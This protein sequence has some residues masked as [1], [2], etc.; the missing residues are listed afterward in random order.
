REETT[1]PPIPTRRTS[2]SLGRREGPRSRPRRGR[3]RHLL[4]PGPRHSGPGLTP[5]EGKQN[6]D[7]DA[8]NSHIHLY[9][10]KKYYFIITFCIVLCAEKIDIPKNRGLRPDLLLWWRSF[11]VLRPASLTASTAGLPAHRRP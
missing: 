6:I 1:T 3:V 8:S 11:R 7:Q 2:G 5:G 4:P 10:N 9:R